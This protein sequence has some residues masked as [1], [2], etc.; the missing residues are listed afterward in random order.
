MGVISYTQAR[1][2]LAELMQK[3][4]D[5]RAPTIITRRN[6]APVVMLSL[7]EYEGLEAT[8]HLLS[9]PKNAE[10]LRESIAQL[11]AGQF[12]TYTLPDPKPE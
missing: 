11:E 1:Q 9:S 3:V 5:E 10:R 4:C 7:E 12:V 8:L 6:G 2:N